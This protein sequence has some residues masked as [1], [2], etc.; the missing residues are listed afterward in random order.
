MYIFL[1]VRIL[2]SILLT[3]VALLINHPIVHILIILFWMA[4]LIYIYI[5]WL[6]HELDLFVVTNNRIV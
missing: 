4:F 2:F 1:G 5:A 6:N 3:G